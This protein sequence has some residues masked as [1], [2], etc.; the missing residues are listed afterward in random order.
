MPDIDYPYMPKDRH[1]K[2]VPADHPFML[3]AK[4]AREECAGDS[5]YPVG[6]VFVKNGEVL[7]SAGNGYNKGAGSVHVCPRIVL[8]IPSGKGYGLCKFHDSPGHAERMLIEECKRLGVDVNGGDAYMYGHWWACEPCWDA[9]IEAGVRDL[10]VTDDA[11]ERFTRDNVFAQTLIPS[12]QTV[13]FEGFDDDLLADVKQHTDELGLKVV[14]QDADVHCVLAEDGTH[15]YLKGSEESVYSI[16]Y[17]DE[18]P[19][20]LRNVFR[21]L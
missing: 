14:D 10:Y 6:I 12:I 20:R 9:L 21:Q 3:A 17:K 8:D 2:Y 1:I 5:I 7:V 11:H 4:H 15:C 18:L 13:S 16:E 19:R